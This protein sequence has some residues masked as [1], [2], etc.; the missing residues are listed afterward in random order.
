MNLPIAVKVKGKR[1]LIIGE[2]EEAELRVQRLGA[3]GAEVECL[4]IADFEPSCLEG[5][6]LVILADRDAKL[7]RQLDELCAQ[8]QR[9][10]C[11]IDQP[12]FGNFAHVALVDASP[13]T[14]AISTS[15]KAPALARRLQQELRKVLCTDAV[16]GFFK[17]LAE[18]RENT[19]KPERRQALEKAMEGFS[20]EGRV[21][22]PDYSKSGK[23]SNGSGA[24]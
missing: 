11:A 21:N 19:P 17:H 13:V 6:W 24:G 4:P 18:L 14:L 23:A 10:F 7:A 9:L 2:S 12:P 8:S 16:V 1:C 15:G 22:L 3:L 20:I 5:A